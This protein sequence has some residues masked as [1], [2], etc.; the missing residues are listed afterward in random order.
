[1]DSHFALQGAFY[2]LLHAN[3]FVEALER[4]IIRGGDTDTNGSI[5]GAL[6]GILST[7]SNKTDFISQALV[8][9]S[10]KS[11]KNGVS[12]CALA[13]PTRENS[14]F[15]TAIFLMRISWQKN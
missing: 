14:F 4:T 1:M 15:L 9:A 6:L 11:Q 8:L 3:T 13:E 12:Q 5:T 10:S 2:E 7:F